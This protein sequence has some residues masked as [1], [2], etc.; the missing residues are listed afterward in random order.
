MTNRLP[1]FRTPFVGRKD[2]RA[3]SVQLLAEH[4]LVTITG[5]ATAAVASLAVQ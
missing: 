2:D 3:L 1:I 5:R 4:S